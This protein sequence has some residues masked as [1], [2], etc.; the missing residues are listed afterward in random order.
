MAKSFLTDIQLNGN[1]LLNAKIQQWGTAPTGTT[2]PNGSG[3]AVQGQ[4]SSYLG[5]LYIFTG[6]TGS[7]AN[8]WVKVGAGTVTSVSGTSGS[9]TVTNGSTTP[10]ISLTAAYGDSVNPYGSK[11]ANFVLAAPNGSNG[12]PSFRA[13]VAADIPTLNQNTTGSAGSTTGTLTFGTGLTAGGSTFNGSGNVTITAVTGSTSVAGILQLSDAINST[14]TS[15]A[16]TANAAKTAYDRG[17]TGITNAATAQSTADAALPKAGGTMTGAIAMGNNKITG[18][19]TP[20]DNGDA[21]TK[22]YVDNVSTGVNI[23]DAV[24]A[25]TTGTIAGVYAAGSTTAN[26]PGDGG[27]G[28]GAT[29]TYSSTGTTTLD[30]SVTLAQFDRVL[31][32]DGVTAAAGASSIANGVYV[33]TT[34]GTTGVATVLTRATDSDNSHFGDLS[35][36]DLVY[37]IGGTL[38][39]GDQFVQTTKGTATQGTGADTTYSVRIGTDAIAYTQFSGAG[40]VPAATTSALGI[41]SFASTQFDVATGAV[42]IKSAAALPSP[43]LTTPTLNGTITLGST[44]SFS[45]AVSFANTLTA[46]GGI[47]MGNL[48]STG[49]NNIVQT[50]GYLE[51]TKIQAANSGDTVLLWNTA[52]TTGSITTGQSLTTGSLNLGNGTAWTTGTINIGNGASGSPTIRIGSGNGTAGTATIAIG[53][54]GQSGTGK[55]T[56]T[57]AGNVLLPQVANSTAGFVKTAS[58]GT[59]SR[60]ATVA[61]SEL[62]NVGSTTATTYATSVTTTVARKATGT[63]GTVAANTAVTVNHGWGLVTAQLFDSSGAQVEVD[64]TTASGITTF[65]SPS[66][67]LTGFQYVIIG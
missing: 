40:S 43:V 26:P 49:V 56:T 55:S 15:L 44:P 22:A 18:L 65:L 39:G 10:T 35:A 58:D 8:T 20:T 36:G 30:T 7:P 27:T 32:K 6:A 48:L 5:E 21:A 41:A 62:A 9:V 13:L 59:L 17:S 31:V 64:V 19:G 34:A 28:V 54:N 37:V 57:I 38:H 53:N 2:N 29:I 61:Y 50:S 52:I 47:T 16:A 42:S 46:T 23:H 63:I 66:T 33:V 67:A 3:T 60:A 14:S 12:V 4:I 11:T 25:A 45:G 1:V 51:T 24:V